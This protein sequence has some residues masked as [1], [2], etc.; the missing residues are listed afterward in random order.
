MGMYDDAARA[1]AD[2]PA[3]PFVAMI[4]PPQDYR[5]VIGGCTTLAA[6]VDFVSRLMFMQQMH[7]TYAGTSTVCTGIAANPSFEL[8][9]TTATRCAGLFTNG[10]GCLSFCAAAGLR[11]AAH[12][13][14]EPG[15]QKESSSFGCSED[16]GHQSDWCE[17]EAD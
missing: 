9:E 4:A 17:C 15:C 6:E 8:C 5:N 11:C 16:T 13:G 1:T 7:K 10:A 2:S 14:G 3:T 12:Y